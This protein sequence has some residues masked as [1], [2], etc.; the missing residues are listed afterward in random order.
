MTKA[1]IQ[2]FFTANN[3]DL[4]YYN[5]DRVFLRS[6]T[7]RDRALYLFNN[8][9][10]LIWKSEGVSFN[11]AIQEPKDIFKIVDN[12]IT[13]K[14][15]KS[16]FEYIYQPKKI[17]SHLTN[18]I[19]YD[20][21][22]HNTNRARPY[23]FCFYRLSKLAGRYNR[24]LTRDEI[25]KCK[26]DYVAF[27]GDNCVEKALD[28]C[29]KLKGEEYNDKKGKVPEYNLQLHAQN[30]SGFD[31]W[32]VLNKLSCDKGIVNIIKNGTG[33]IELKVFNGHFEKNKKQSAQYL[34]FRCGMT[35]LKYSLKKLGKT[36]KLQ[37][38]LLETEMNHDEIDYIKYKDKINDWL[39]YV[40]NDVLCTAFSYARYIKAMEEI[41]GFSMK[42]CLSLPGLGLK[43]FRSFRTEEDEPIYTYNDKYMR[44]FVRQ[45]AYGGRVCA[46][47][48]YFKSKNC[49]NI[50]KIISQEL[51]LKEVYMTK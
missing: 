3:I 28:F 41:T 11:Q 24:D 4:G 26:K 30:G 6:V 34:H 48:Q 32:I 42:D 20:L 19:V 13:E 46:F 18:F 8:H 36:F 40:K 35:H 45:A 2:P 10:C 44:W 1:R 22:S 7:T 12:S 49:D 50:L 27:D 16:H 33:I 23:V 51:N 15:V 9:F 38:E 29:L 37:K 47:N 17:Q 25:D 43:Y 21:E 14:N 31:N 39:P 5:D